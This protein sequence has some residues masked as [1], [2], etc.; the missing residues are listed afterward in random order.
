MVKFFPLAVLFCR[1]R[2]WVLFELCLGDENS[3]LQRLFKSPLHPTM[4]Y[5]KKL[6]D[7]AG[8]SP[9]HKIS[10][11]CALHFK[12]VMENKMIGIDA[13]INHARLELIE[14]NRVRLRPIIGAILTCARQNIPLRGH[15]DDNHY[16]LGDDQIN[17]GNFIEI[18][19]LALLVATSPMSYSNQTCR[20]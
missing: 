1:C 9:I 20:S 4:S 7:H 18:L 19:K 16:Y 10:T 2:R 14:K 11:V 17:P 12:Q 5:V 8:K 15:R 13:Q 6:E 3:K